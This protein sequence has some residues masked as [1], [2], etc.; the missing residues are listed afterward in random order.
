MRSPEQVEAWVLS[1]VDRVR[2][3]QPIEDDRVELKA[4]WPDATKAARRLAGHANASGGGSVLWIIGLDDQRGV[5]PFSGTDPAIWVQQLHAQFDGLGPSVET[6]S[7]P[8]GGGGVYALLFDTARRPFVVKNSVHGSPGT[9]PVSLEVP[10]REGTSV[11][12]ARRED[13]IRL[14]VP[15]LHLP[16]FEVLQANASAFPVAAS[17]KH[18]STRL[19]WSVSLELYVTPRTSDRVVLPVHRVSLELLNPGQEALQMEDISLKAPYWLLS[20]GSRADS[21]TIAATSSEAIISGPGRLLV[22]GGFHEPEFPLSANTPDASVRL[23]LMAAGDDQTMEI[24]AHLLPI[25]PPLGNPDGT[26]KNWE[27]TL[28]GTRATGSRI[29]APVLVERL[30]WAVS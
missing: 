6:L 2:E 19:G 1:I 23:R 13:L 12:S 8:T 24:F 30:D 21:Y 28:T 25:A 4:D 27:W 16:T 20:S 10:W 14:L 5:L 9:G 26:T 7:V 17:E 11:R 15:A 3:R 29:A 22:A 18:P